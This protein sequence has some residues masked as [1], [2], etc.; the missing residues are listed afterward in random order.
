VL[1]EESADAGRLPLARDEWQDLVSRL[2]AVIERMRSGC[3]ILDGESRIAGWNTAARLLFGK[4]TSEVLGKVPGG[5]LIPENAWEDFE[6]IYRQA[7]QAGLSTCAVLE[8]ELVDGRKEACEWR[9]AALK[10]PDG[11]VVGYTAMVEERDMA[12]EPVLEESC[13]ETVFDQTPVPTFLLTQE[14]RI[15]KA[16]E[17]ARMLFE[18]QRGTLLGTSLGEILACPAESSGASGCGFDPRC[19]I[20]GLDEALKAASRKG[21]PIRRREVRQTVQHRDGPYEARLMVSASPVRREGRSMILVSLE[22]V[23]ERRRNEDRLREQAMLL[24]AAEDA[25][26][27]V[28]SEGR[29]EFWSP[30]A[31]RLYGWPASEAKGQAVADILF[32]GASY[33]WSGLRGMVLEKGTWE[34][35]LEPY[36]RKKE[37]LTVRAR[38]WVMTGATDEDSTMVIVATDQTGTRRLEKQL[39]RAQR[40]ESVGTLTCGIVHDLN[41]V[42]TPVQMAAELLRPSVAGTDGERFLNLLVRSAVRGVEITRQLLSFGRGNEGG[43]ASVDLRVL[44]KEMVRMLAGTLPKCI[45]VRGD[46]PESLWPVVADVTQM[47]QVLL[48]LC[49]NARDAMSEGGMMTVLARNRELDD[50]GA[51]ALKDGRPGRFVVLSVR[52]TGTGISGEVMDRMFDPFFSTKPPAMGSGLGLS[53]VQSI[54]RDHRGFISVTTEIGRGSEFSIYLPAAD[55]APVVPLAPETPISPHG[56]GQGLLVVEDDE[57]IRELIQSTLE[58]AGYR[59]MTAADGAEAISVFGK[60]QGEVTVVVL[61]MVLPLIDGG[62]VVR[63][64]RKLRPDVEIVAMSDLPLTSLGTE[65]SGAGRLGWLQKPIRVDEMLAAVGSAISR[66]ASPQAK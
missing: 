65:T 16:N 63:M 7:G 61:D 64:I 50:V 21:A 9:M 42:L 26:C 13:W 55:D 2:E 40:L 45:Q 66:S 1:K 17:A 46:V 22:D 53:T 14:G 11:V 23:T 44:I 54:V 43:R 49:V 12:P 34:G 57:S 6:S 33:V 15:G 28:D 5:L 30:G 31:E 10:R 27:I 32:G 47:H 39:L 18:R 3:V 19:A 48:N 41:N 52:D 56:Q 8:R 60:N 25:I 59:V 36:S 29:I 58:H 4:E 38:A 62:T 37:S 20:C 35:D 24:A 51:G